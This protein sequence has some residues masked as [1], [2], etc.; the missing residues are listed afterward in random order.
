LVDDICVAPVGFDASS[1]VLTGQSGITNFVLFS[2]TNNELILSRPPAFTAPSNVA[3]TFSP[4]TN[5][6][7]GGSYFARIYTYA[8]SDASGV[9]TDSG[10]LALYYT[11][12]FG[13]AA[14]VPP[15][16]TFCVGESISGFNCST[17]TDP[18]SDLGILGP[19]VTGSAQSQMVV[20]TN[21]DSGY[22]TFVSG[23]T[24]TSGSNVVPA[25]AGGPSVKGTAQFGIN[26]RANTTPIV[27]QDV[28]GP[29]VAG[30]SGGYSV[31]NQ[32]RY[33][34][35]DVLAT[36]TAPDDY[37]KYTVSYIVNV[38]ANQPG[39]VYSTTLTYITLA[40]F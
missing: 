37:R 40:N 24:M 10:G 33:Q 31:Q 35:G 27:G 23:G 13:V 18:F 3:Y 30:I 11:P 6:L 1:A 26:L 8:T 16:L 2:S 19:L 25:M 12:S 20:A 28:A 29:G 36:A 14:E 9:E 34:S 39:G 17:A 5:P 15:Y 38:P 4:I 21:A 22:S 7:T 32:F